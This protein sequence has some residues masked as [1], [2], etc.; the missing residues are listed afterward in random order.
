MKII[1]FVKN[2][3]VLAFVGGILTATYGVKVLKSDKARKTAVS[4]LA[5]CIKL[6]NDA[7]EDF[8]EYERRSGRYICYDAKQEASA[9]L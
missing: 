8:Q 2:E 4:G 6:Q 7:R 9:E 3:K 5:K 1:D